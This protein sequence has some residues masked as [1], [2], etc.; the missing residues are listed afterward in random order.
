M[1]LLLEQVLRAWDSNGFSEGD[2][3]HPR[4]PVGTAAGHRQPN[5]PGKQGNPG[6]QPATLPKNPVEAV[7]RMTM[8]VLSPWTFPM[9]DPAGRLDRDRI[10]ENVDRAD[11]RNP[12][13]LGRGS[14]LAAGPSY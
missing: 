14:R 3:T 8:N 11:A 12:R 1:P 6:K 2:G 7:A 5:H 13:D 9:P 10:N 4:A